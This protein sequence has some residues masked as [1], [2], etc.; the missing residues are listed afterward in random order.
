[1]VLRF[2]IKGSESMEMCCSCS[3]HFPVHSVMKGS[4]SIDSWKYFPHDLCIPLANVWAHVQFFSALEL[5]K[6]CKAG[7]DWIYPSFQPMPRFG[8][9]WFSLIRKQI[10][11]LGPCCSCVLMNCVMNAIPLTL[12]VSSAEGDLMW[13]Q[14]RW[15]WFGMLCT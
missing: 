8:Y 9:I 10:P 6:R 3:G 2:C 15:E 5:S 4:H 14:W 12:S 13:Q 7:T 1:M 11:F